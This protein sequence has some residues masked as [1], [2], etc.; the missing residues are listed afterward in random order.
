[1]DA[2]DVDHI[3][4]VANDGEADQN[5]LLCPWHDRHKGDRM[6]AGPDPPSADTG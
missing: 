6:P 2:G 3:V 1:M 5:T 4:P